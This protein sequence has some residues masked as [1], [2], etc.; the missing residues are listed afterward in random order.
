MEVAKNM[1]LNSTDYSGAVKQVHEKIACKK[2][3]SIF[4]QNLE[5]KGSNATW[6]C[7][8]DDLWKNM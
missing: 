2:W 8:I 3:A 4:V 7:N 6:K 1:D 5:D